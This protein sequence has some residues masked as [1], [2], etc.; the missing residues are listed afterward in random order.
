MGAGTLRQ[1]QTTAAVAAM[2]ACCACLGSTAAEAGFGSTESLVNNLFAYYG[3]GSPE[4]SAGL[5]RD[6]VTAR[7]FFHPALARLWLAPS[8]RPFD[9][10]VQAASWRIGPV[11]ITGTI[12]HYDR[13]FVRV[14]FRNGDKPIVLNIV[15]VK[16]D[17]GW[18]IA[19]VESTYDSLTS[20][21][22]RLRDDDIARPITTAK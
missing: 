3:K 18:V 7:R 20:Y 5:P 21:L 4:Y 13:S 6:E 16:G 15:T 19:D 2:A 1:C 9:F 17:D 22:T 8:P 10:L 12:K 11:A 14:A